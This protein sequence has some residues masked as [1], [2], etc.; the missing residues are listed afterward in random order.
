MELERRKYV[1]DIFCKHETQK[2]PES[3]NCDLTYVWI[4]SFTFLRVWLDADV[5]QPRKI[6]VLSIL[7]ISPLQ[8]PYG[9]GIW[10]CRIG[11]ERNIWKVKADCELKRNRQKEAREAGFFLI[12]F[13]DAVRKKTGLCGENSQ[14][15]CEGYMGRLRR[16]YGKIPNQK[17]I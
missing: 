9:L 2:N 3:I 10:W 7:G 13:R 15:D 14:E 4:H 5:L 16:L 17:P 11:T 6:L 8:S 12:S 1:L